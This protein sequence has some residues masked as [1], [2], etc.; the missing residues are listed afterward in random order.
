MSKEGRKTPI[1]YTVTATYPS[2]H[3]SV[4]YGFGTREEGQKKAD[5]LLANGYLDVKITFADG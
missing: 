1:A 3:R 5:E 4:G 2:N